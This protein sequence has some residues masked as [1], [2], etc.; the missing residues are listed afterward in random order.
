MAPEKWVR[1][2]QLA[3]KRQARRDYCG[4][5]LVYLHLR[6]WGRACLGKAT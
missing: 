6:M 5:W 3:M 1:Q 2:Q 4:R